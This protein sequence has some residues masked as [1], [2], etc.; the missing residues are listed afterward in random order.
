MSTLITGYIGLDEPCSIPFSSY[1]CDV[2]F[3]GDR[4]KITGVTDE[5]APS[6]TAYILKVLGSSRMF[7]SLPSV[8]RHFHVISLKR[9]RQDKHCWWQH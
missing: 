8:R 2:T 7:E 6:W 4:Q 1:Y 9:W 5:P 3:W